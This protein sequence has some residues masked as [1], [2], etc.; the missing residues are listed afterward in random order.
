VSQIYNIQARFIY[1]TSGS[2][3]GGGIGEIR[4]ICSV[5]R[6]RSD[7]PSVNTSQ[8]HNPFP[9]FWFPTSAPPHQSTMAVGN[10]ARRG[11]KTISSQRPTT[12]SPSSQRKGG[13]GLGKGIAHRH[14]RR[15]VRKD[16]IQGITKGDLR[17]LARRGGVKRMSGSVYTQARVYLKEFLTEV[18]WFW[19]F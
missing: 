19:G 13:L 2:C 10:F 12:S 8:N 17:R 7:A 15:R 11:G 3:G 6:A 16:N 9:V 14:A 4:P 5:R 1:P 18:Y